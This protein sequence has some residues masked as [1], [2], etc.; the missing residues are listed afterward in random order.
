M[1]LSIV[2]V[3]LLCAAVPAG[4]QI[5][6]T[7]VPKARPTATGDFEW[8]LGA[9][10][11]GGYSFWDF[12]S[13]DTEPA[14]GEP[15]DG[16]LVAADV[17][18]RVSES[19]TVGV[20][21]WYNDT[22]EYDPNDVIPR[23]DVEHRFKRSMYSI[24]GS[25]FY[26]IVGIQA[27]I[28][29]V[30]VKQTTTVKATGVTVADDDGGQVDA[31]VFAVARLGADEA[32]PMGISVAAGFGIRR[33]GARDANA[34]TG[35]APASPSSIAAAGFGT[36]AF[37]VYRRLSADASFWYSYGDKAGGFGGVGNRSDLRAS[38]GIGYQ[39]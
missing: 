10:L 33:Y 23:Y 13:T 1:R 24:Y 11:F 7:T 2:A 32:D 39:F 9:H 22:S 36:F 28:V 31:T 18:K 16:Y 3:T 8:P 35:T 14:L 30:R 6:V 25:A 34:G 17:G 4:A 27:G 15:R 29:P 38:V 19:I 21:G 37:K 12:G 5:I 20:G 26:K